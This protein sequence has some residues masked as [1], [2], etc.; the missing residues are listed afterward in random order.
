MR[1]SIEYESVIERAKD[2]DKLRAK[3]GQFLFPGTEK[4]C[5]YTR[6]D[7]PFDSDTV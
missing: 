7:F 6:S 5:F 4:S 1:E 3:V 2:Q